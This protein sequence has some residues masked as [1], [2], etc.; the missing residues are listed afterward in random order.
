ML[1]I[2]DLR[3]YGIVYVNGKRIGVLD[4]RLKQ[5]SLQLDVPKGKCLLDILVEN[6]GR[7]NFGPYLLHNKKGITETVMLGGK[8]LNNWKMYSL[9]FA[10]S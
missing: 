9:P 3:D 8:E 2:K 6:M 10:I 1:K 4:R 7:I 5:D